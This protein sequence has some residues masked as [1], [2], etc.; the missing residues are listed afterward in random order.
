MI[1]CG[2]TIRIGYFGSF[3][4]GEIPPNTLFGLTLAERENNE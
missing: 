4:G 2:V 1:T 3:V